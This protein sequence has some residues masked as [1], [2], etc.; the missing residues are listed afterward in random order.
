MVE[1]NL[2]NRSLEAVIAEAC[3]RGVTVMVKKGLASGRLD[4]RAA[5]EFVLSNAGVTS[6]VVGGLSLDHLGDNLRLAREVRGMA[7]NESGC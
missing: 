7:V 6:L 1:Y 3:D 2:E 4:A 5:I